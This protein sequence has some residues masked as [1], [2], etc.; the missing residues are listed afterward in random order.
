[1]A[2]WKKAISVVATT[3]LLAGALVGCAGGGDEKK[4]E[5]TKEGDKP[6]ATGG[7]IT[8][9]SHWGDKE[10]EALKS[11]A[12]DWAKST[13]NEVEVVNDKS[14]F[15]QYA[16]AARSGKGPDVMFGIPHDNL[17]TF[18]KAGLLEEVPAKVLTEGDFEKVAVSAITVNGKKVGYPI[19]METY[20]VFYNTEKVKEAPKTWDAFLAAAKEHGFMYDVNNIYFSYPFISGNGGYVFKNNGGTYDVKDIG[21]GN[22]GA[23]KGYATIQD[24][25]Q[26]H[27]FMPADVT[28]DIAKAKFSTKATGLYIS[29]PWDVP[30]MKDKVQ[31]KVAPL[32]T[33]E[34]GAAAKNFVGVQTAFVSAKSEKKDKA[35][36]LIKYISDNGFKK[37]LE[38]GARIPVVKKQLEDQAFKS[39]EIA[40]SFAAIAAQGE[41]MPNIPEIQAMWTPA[42]NNL[43]LLTQGKSSPDK[44]AKD[45]VDQITK[46]IATQQ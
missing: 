11:V 32:P 23:V 31:F 18:A 10:L 37:F 45:V 46:G 12:Q 2:S 22:A 9:W 34:G 35:F 13:G 40:A 5:A 16:T 30:A 21:L 33:L 15:Q 14:E 19:S 42:N 8:V 28:G 29:G 24:F 44:V 6:A 3:G 27:K 7:K 36:E 4:E 39:N 41:P 20:G 26:K 38:V 25:V 43:K 1:M 17:G